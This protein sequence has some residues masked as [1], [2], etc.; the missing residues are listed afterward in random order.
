[1]IHY[2]EQR[3]TL[4]VRDDGNGM[5]LEAVKETAHPGHRGLQG[6]RERASK[7]GAQRELWSRPGTGTEVELRI[8]GANAYEILARRFEVVLV[9]S[10]RREGFGL[11]SD[12]VHAIRMASV[13]GIGFRPAGI[14][15]K[16]LC[17]F[18]RFPLCLEFLAVTFL[19]A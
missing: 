10:F 2:D 6:M 13:P 1:V 12:R 7:I 17:G 19:I 4:H 18:W 16:R 14:G 9:P 11:V 5:G 15:S 3:L 8:P